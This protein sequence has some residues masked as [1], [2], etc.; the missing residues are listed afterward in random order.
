[1]VCITEALEYFKLGLNEI[2]I[3]SIGTGLQ[4]ID[5]TISD[6]KYWGVKQWLPFRIPSM[7]VTPKLLD[8]AL[9][10]SSESVTYQCKQLLGGNYLRINKELGGEVP[11]DDIT[12][13]DQLIEAG[14]KAFIERKDEI[15]D[16][17]DMD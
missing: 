11:F 9:Q 15:A 17:I 5:F 14:R 4:K 12:F 8:L 7:K 2:N 10:L 1:M 6:N 13:M 3:L 16:F